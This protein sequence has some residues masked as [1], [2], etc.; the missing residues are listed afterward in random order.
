M[1]RAFIMWLASPVYEVRLINTKSGKDVPGTRLF[2]GSYFGARKVMAKKKLKYGEM[3]RLQA[4]AVLDHRINSTN[5][6]HE[7]PMVVIPSDM[8]IVDE[9][10]EISQ[11]AWDAAAP[12]DGIMNQPKLHKDIGKPVYGIAE[13]NAS[14]SEFMHEHQD[15]PNV[16]G[17]EDP[18]DHKCDD[19]GPQDWNTETDTYQITCSICGAFYA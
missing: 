8:I 14:Q 6:I 16:Y 12:E 1:F 10:S 4:V 7:E 13:R 3:I 5:P 15:E 19:M 2:R 18:F 9:A 11:E 17:G